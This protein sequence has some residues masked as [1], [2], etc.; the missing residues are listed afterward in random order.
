[1]PP[2]HDLHPYGRADPRLPA[3]LRR[4]RSASPNASA[5]GPR[6][7]S[8][9]PGWEVDGESFDAVIVA[10]GRFRAPVLPP[11]LDGFRGEVLHAYDYPGADHFA[12]P[13]R[14]RLRQRRERARDR[15]RHRDRH[16]GDPRPTAN[17]ATCCR[18]TSTGSRPT[19]SGTRTSAR[20]GAQ[21]C[22]RT[23]TD[24]WCASGCCA[25]P[26]IPPTSARPSPTANFL[27][28]GHSLCQDYLAQVRAGAI[29]CRPAIDA[30]DRRPRDVHRRQFRARR[31]DRLR[32][33]LPARHPLPV[34]RPVVACSAPTCACTAARC[35]RTCPAS[36]S[37]DS[38]R[39]RARTSRC[40]SCRRAGS[41]GC[42]P[43]RSRRPTSRAAR[44]DIAVQPA[45]DRLA[46]RPRRA[47]VRCRRRRARSRA[48]TRTW[49]RRCCSDRCSRRATGSTARA[50]APTPPRC[51]PSSSPFTPRSDR[52]RRRRRARRPRAGRSHGGSR[53]QEPE[54][55]S[56]A[57]TC[58]SQTGLSDEA[59]AAHRSLR[60]TGSLV[61][62][63]VCRR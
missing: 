14:P 3:L 47:A 13:S 15:L 41:S 29:T 17:P 27:V 58:E 22:A 56:R 32:D 11:G 53:S 45:R 59:N 48:R 39:C 60:T 61:R 38:S 28:A 9:R 18:R 63:G 37:S 42:G 30:V 7:T 51:S 21:P 40:S 4:Q 5:S 2:T 62:R 25:S 43:A 24:A 34:R 33:R 55:G 20:C 8:V 46:Q 23:T 36:A 57:G 50:P 19:G 12:R 26:A 1:M 44:A 6:S 16:A 52:A 10:S 54:D 49:P 31:R 35:I